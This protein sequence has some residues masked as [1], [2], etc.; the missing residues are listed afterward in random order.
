VVRKKFFEAEYAFFRKHIK[1]NNVLVAGSGLGDDSFVLAEFNK[2]VIGVELLSDL[3]D[4]ARERCS[5]KGLKNTSFEAGDFTNLKYS[6][7]YFDAAVLNMGTIGNFDDK[8]VVIKEL[9][10][11]SNKLFFDFYLPG[12]NNLR[13]RLKMYVEEGIDE[14]GNFVIDE[15]EEKIYNEAGFE[16]T[17]YSPEEITKIIE[18]AGGQAKFHSFH[19]FSVMAEVVK[20]HNGN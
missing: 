1:N 12:L 10:R 19:E 9:L 14:M 3:I 5:A 13:N 2:S 17:S 11:V 20:S 7:N 18:Q 8:V 15:K 4:I 6:D 16:S